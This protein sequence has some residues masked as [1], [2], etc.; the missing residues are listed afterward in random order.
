M[1]LVLVSGFYFSTLVRVVYFKINRYGNNPYI[2]MQFAMYELICALCAFLLSRQA[3]YP[4]LSL[5]W[6]GY[7]AKP[8]AQL[9][10]LRKK[11]HELEIG[12]ELSS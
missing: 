12:K 7:I 4:L 5:L 3:H 9:L 1:I 6:L 10:L 8:F 11:Y 2:V